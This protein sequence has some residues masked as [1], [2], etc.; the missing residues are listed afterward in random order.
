MPI[1]K[2]AR[3]KHPYAQIDRR[4]LA[5]ARLSLKA[6]GLL[7]YLLS[8]PD[9]WEIHTSEI[10]KHSTDG[11][12]AHREAF[13]ELLKLGYATCEKKRSADNSRIEGSIWTIHETTVG[14]FLESRKTESWKADATNKEETDR[15]R[16]HTSEQKPRAGTFGINVESTLERLT[17]KFQR[18]SEKQNFHLGTGDRAD[19]KGWTK[20]T[21]RKWLF[22][23][24]KLHQQLGNIKTIERVMD[25]YVD[26]YGE[27]FMPNAETLPTFCFKFRKIQAAMKREDP[28]E[29]QDDPGPGA[30]ARIKWNGKYVDEMEENED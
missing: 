11:S 10:F 21:I 4:T 7:A 18:F 19:K 30:S 6:K 25:W 17:K 14:G 2:T 13:R 1:V 23:L 28:D 8:L 29:V 20:W 27:E 22:A 16:T 26:H 3:R 5:D 15:H 9:D 12:Y 24:E